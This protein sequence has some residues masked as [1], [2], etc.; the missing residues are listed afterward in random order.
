[1]F[2]HI[3]WNVRLIVMLTVGFTPPILWFLCNAKRNKSL[4]ALTRRLYLSGVVGTALSFPALLLVGRF[5]DPS[6]VSN[7]S[8]GTRIGSPACLLPGYV[9]WYFAI[10]RQTARQPS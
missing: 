9:L 8:H 3:F 6:L 2:G 4:L 1:M 5:I 7:R 10:F